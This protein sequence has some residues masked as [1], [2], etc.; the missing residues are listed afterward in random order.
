M[1]CKNKRSDAEIVSDFWRRVNRGTKKECW[2]WMGG[3]NGNTRITSYGVFWARRKK[4]KAHRFAFELS[5]RSLRAGECACHSCDNPPCCNPAHLFAGTNA[6]N[7][8]DSIAKGRAHRECGEQRYNAKLTE[9][10]V[11]EIRRIYQK[12]KR[13]GMSGVRLAELYGVYPTMIHAIVTR[14]R[15]K[16]VI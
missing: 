12:R 1:R 3:R 5:H 6:D 2:E 4:Y 15:W 14:Q 10:D 9:N 11:R 16:H 7:M 13:D 8:R